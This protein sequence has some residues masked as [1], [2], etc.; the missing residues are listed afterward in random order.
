MAIAIAIL[1]SLAFIGWLIYRAVKGR[2]IKAH[3]V[4]Y[5]LA[6]IAGVYTYAFFLSMDIPQLIKVVISI[7]LGVA[8]IILAASLQRHRQPGKTQVRQ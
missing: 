8:L 3:T 7:L 2:Q 5:G 1:A 4:S 6:C